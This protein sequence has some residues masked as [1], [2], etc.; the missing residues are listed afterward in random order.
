MTQ[1]TKTDLPENW[2]RS[3]HTCQ[4]LSGLYRRHLLAMHVHCRIAGDFRQEILTGFLLDI[5]THV[6]WVTAG[7]VIDHLQEMLRASDVSGMKAGWMDHHEDPNAT[8]MPL[9]LEST[10]MYS[11]T[12]S[13]GGDWGCIALRPMYR[14]MIASN[15]R[16]EALLPAVWRGIDDSHVAGFHLVGMA[17]ELAKHEI[18]SVRDGK[19]VWRSEITTQC[20]PV[21][22]LF[23][24]EPNTDSTFWDHPGDFF[25]Q[26][27][28]F[29]DCPIPCDI[30][31]KGMSGG[32]VFSIEEE[33]ESEIR[34]RLVGVQSAWLKTPRIVRATSIHAIAKTIEAFW[35]MLRTA[36][37]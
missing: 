17:A 30:N 9:D 23:I 11:A 19:R 32:P 7:H 24:P 34:Y 8:T 20:L 31:I 13:E 5:G 29:A 14:E 3:L 12:Q 15:P 27:T 18:V 36:Q 22:R 26:L 6:F 16:V 37:S 10:P 4:T 2:W 35:S 33:G 21:E 1:E 28:N 25:G